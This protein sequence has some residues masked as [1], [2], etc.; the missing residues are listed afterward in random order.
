MFQ[1]T[2]QSSVSGKNKVVVTIVEALT[3]RVFHIQLALPCSNFFL[4]H[5][6]IVECHCFCFEFCPAG[7]SNSLPPDQEYGAKTKELAI[8]LRLSGPLPDSLH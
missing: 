5:L 7:D 4:L 8:H 3:P 1:A 6:N 2:K